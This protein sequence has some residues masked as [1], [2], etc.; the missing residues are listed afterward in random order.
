PKGRNDPDFHPK[1]ALAWQLI[2]EARAASIPFRLVVADAVYGE[3]LT[4]EARL[5]AA[6]IPYIMGLKP[7]HGTWQEAAAP[8]HQPAFTPPPAAACPRAQRAA[9]SP[10]GARQHTG[11][12]DRH[13]K[14]LVRSIAELELD[15]SYGPTQP[16]RLVAAALDPERLTPESTWYLATSLPLGEVSA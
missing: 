2:E 8:A 11:R 15:P 13:G 6:H 4:L 5:Y 10:V 7:A 16:T 3:Q 1:P 9:R 14:E 12:F